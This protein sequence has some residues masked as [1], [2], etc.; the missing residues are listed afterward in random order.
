M[1]TDKATES[2]VQPTIQRFDGHYNHRS[3]LMENFLR[4][5]KYWNLVES[6]ID[7]LEKGVMLTEQ[8]Q[9]RV[10]EQKLKDLKVKTTFF[11]HLI[12]QFWRPYSRMRP[13]NKYGFL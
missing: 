10:A 7:T 9:K 8:Q 2:F 4:S 13:P 6:G 12:D 5:K 3:M 1:A 11:R